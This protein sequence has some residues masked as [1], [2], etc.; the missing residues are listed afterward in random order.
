MNSLAPAHNPNLL[1][2]P[3]WRSS[4]RVSP[5][6][7]PLDLN[8]TLGVHGALHM[9]ANQGHDTERAASQR[10]MIVLIPKD[11]RDGRS[12]ERWEAHWL[13][14]DAQRLAERSFPVE[15]FGAVRRLEIGS[16]SEV[17]VSIPE[18]GMYRVR[19]SSETPMIVRQSG[20]DGIFKTRLAPGDWIGSLHQTVRRFFGPLPWLDEIHV[21]YDRWQAGKSLHETKWST[22]REPAFAWEWDGEVNACGLL[23]LRI[24]EQL[25]IGARVSRGFGRLRVTAC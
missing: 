2:L 1:Y 19:V 11:S 18:P 25:G 21:R 12:A 20:R 8:A 3:G 7:W 13:H 9:L 5:L 10:P 22:G 17:A 4:L 15:L 24:V 6:K 23:A 14:A 16:F